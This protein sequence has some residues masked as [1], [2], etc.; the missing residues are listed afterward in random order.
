MYEGAQYLYGGPRVRNDVR[1]QEDVDVVGIRVPVPDPWEMAQFA[2]THLVGNGMDADEVL[3]AM[4]GD[5]PVGEL[6][7]G[8]MGI[9][10]LEWVQRFRRAFAETVAGAGGISGIEGGG[11]ES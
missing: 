10:G 9:F 6:G 11:D 1:M 3:L 7:L 5:Y 8:L 4:T 2:V